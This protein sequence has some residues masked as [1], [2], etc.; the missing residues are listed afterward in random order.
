LPEMASSG[1]L[2]RGGRGALLLKVASYC[3]LFVWLYLYYF[4]STHTFCSSTE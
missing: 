2:G 1:G 3:S 4:S